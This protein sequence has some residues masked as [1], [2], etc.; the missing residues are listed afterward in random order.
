MLHPQKKLPAAKASLSA[1]V[2]LNNGENRRTKARDV[3]LMF[4]DDTH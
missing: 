2:Q 4:L 3:D 1:P